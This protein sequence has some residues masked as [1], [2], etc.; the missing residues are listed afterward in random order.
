MSQ[1]KPRDWGLFIVGIVLVVLALLI[2]FFPTFTMVTVTT[3]V[4]IGLLVVGIMGIVEYIRM[5]P[6]MLPL[7]WTLIYSVL[8]IIIGL[9]LITHP[10]IFSSMLVW[11]VG[12]FAIAFG[13]FGIVGA[14][15][16]RDHGDEYWV[17]GLVT[18][19]VDIICG[20]LFFVNPSSIV[21]ILAI[22][23]GIHGVE[24]IVYG[25]NNDFQR[26]DGGRMGGYGSGRSGRTGRSG[27]S[28]GSDG[29]YDGNPPTAKR[30]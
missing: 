5:G 17:M 12:L 11:L 18:G 21:V 29:G 28:G 23:L 27:R 20:I 1:S 22:F 14:L 4:G 13:I 7:A 19:I 6:L 3:L 16:M 25:W 30:V 2:A 26:P 8:A 24:L 10:L 15:G 9:L